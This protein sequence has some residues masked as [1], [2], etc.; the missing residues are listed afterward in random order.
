[1]SRIVVAG[2]VA[3]VVAYLVDWVMW[4]YVFRKGMDA[5]VTPMSPEEMKRFMGPALAKSGVLS[6]VFGVLLA[7]LYARFRGSLWVQGGGPLAGL[8]FGAVLWLPTIALETL[9]GGVWYAKVRPLFNA[10]FWVWLA[11]LLAAGLVVGL[12]ITE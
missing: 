1:M 12:L 2:V 7:F 4:S 5:F 10:T 9:G 11:R 3:G 8:E 6:L